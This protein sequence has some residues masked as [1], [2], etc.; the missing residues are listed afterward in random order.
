MTP[1]TRRTAAMDRAAAHGIRWHESLGAPTRR[2]RSR[3]WRRVLLL[4]LITAAALLIV[5]G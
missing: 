3:P 2:A 4:T 5:F 1:P